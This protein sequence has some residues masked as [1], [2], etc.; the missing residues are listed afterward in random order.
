MADPLFLDTTAHDYHLRPGSPCIDT[1]DPASPIDPDGSR[2]DMGWL[3]FVLPRPVLSVPAV[4]TIGFQFRLT[5]YTNRN[6]AID[7]STN[8]RTW[9]TLTTISHRADPETV[10]TP[11]P[12][13]P[14]RIYRARLVP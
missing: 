7:Y 5:G 10:T 14:M 6:Y 13:S 8:A 1:G 3:T 11:L 4:G 12:E 9:S 2:V